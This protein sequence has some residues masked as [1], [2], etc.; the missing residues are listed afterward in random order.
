MSS[1]YALM[2]DVEAIYEK[3]DERIAELELDLREAKQRVVELSSQLIE[4]Q[5]KNKVLQENVSDYS[6]YAV[7]T[8][9]SQEDEIVKLRREVYKLMRQNRVLRR[10]SGVGE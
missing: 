9:I 7:G 6:E 10:I 2:S 8:S 1:F 5:R 3:Q 4:E